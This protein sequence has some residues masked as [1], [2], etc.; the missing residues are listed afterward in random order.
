M[1]LRGPARP[2]HFEKYRLQVTPLSPIHV[3]AGWTL[4]PMEYDLEKQG[5]AWFLHVYDLPAMVSGLDP[6]ARAEMDRIIDQGDLPGIRT[7]LRGRF[8]QK[9]HARFSVQVQAGAAKEIHDGLSNPNR[10]GEIELSARHPATGRPYFPGSSVKGA[11]RTALLAR[12]TEGESRSH[13]LLTAHSQNA[14]QRGSARFEAVILGNVR[15]SGAPD[16]YR[17]PFRQIA[18]SDCVLPQDAC[19]IDRMKIIRPIDRRGTGAGDAGKIIMYRDVTWSMLDDDAVVPAA[20]ELRLHR[21]LA[22]AKRM[23][24][25]SILPRDLP[26]REIIEACNTFHLPKLRSELDRFASGANRSMLAQLEGWAA[27][28]SPQEC[29][30]RLGRHHH[31]EC[32]T[33]GDPWRIAPKRGF[34]GTRTWV[35][36]ELSLGWAKLRFER[37]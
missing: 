15:G 17:D 27:A 23:D 28:L 4:E 5:D 11:I 16:L 36:G 18:V 3:G 34:G 35:Q 7:W 20:G 22:D 19:Y 14:Q 26:L 9:Q 8:I 6:K 12:F 2:A 32:G 25:D 24:R 33:L 13:R 31:Y 37:A 21:E 29:L 30:I 1:T 10:I